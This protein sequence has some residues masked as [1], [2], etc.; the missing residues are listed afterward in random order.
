M[1]VNRNVIVGVAKIVYVS[2]T[3]SRTVYKVESIII[4][5]NEIAVSYFLSFNKKQVSYHSYKK[6]MRLYLSIV[7]D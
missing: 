4:A 7:Q 5:G 3:E 1:G 6:T 2:F